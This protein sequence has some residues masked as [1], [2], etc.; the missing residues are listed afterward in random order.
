[1]E[2]PV[3]ERSDGLIGMWLD[4][5]YHVEAV[6]AR[7]GMSRVYR[8][9][10]T[11]L[12]RP[13]AI[14]VMERGYAAD[15]VFLERFEREARAAARLHHPGVV[16]VFDQGVDRSGETDHVFLV[17]ELVEGGTLRDLLRER[18]PLAVPLALSL[19]EPV[20]SALAAA[21][22]EG[23]VHRDVKPE[24]VL[25]GRGGAVK[26]ADFG[27]VR[28]AAEA[29]TSTGNVILGTVAYL[30]PEQVSTGAAD[31]RSDVYAAGIL[32]FELLTGRPPY[33]GETALAVAYRHVN[34]DVPA[35]SEIVPWLPTALD[36][37]VLRAT[38]RDPASRP[39]D[40]SAF[41]LA[42]QQLR[43]KLDIR[44]VPV[45]VPAAGPGGSTESGTAAANAAEPN[46]AEPNAAGSSGADG[47]PSGTRAMTR[48]DLPA[49]KPAAR[50]A[51]AH[52]PGPDSYQQQRLRS[53]RA[54]LAWL[55]VVL[56]L[57]SA[58]GTAAWW[59]GAGRWTSVPELAGL[60]RAAAAAALESAGLDARLVD[61]HH[62]TVTPGLVIGSEP[63]GGDRALRNTD[64][65]V[66][67]S[68][69]RPVVPDLPN[70]IS[71]DEA[72]QIVTDTDLRPVRNP[73]AAEF[74]D[75]VAEGDVVGLRPAAGTVLMVGAPVTL[76]ISRGPA[77]TTVPD[78][79]G[80]TEADATEALA[81]AG[82][83]VADVERQF[84]QD[85][86]GGQVIGT[87]PEAG[88]DTVRGTD[89]TL[90]VSTALVVP[91]VVGQQR[92]DALAALRDAGFEPEQ[93]GAG[94]GE[95]GATVAALDPR[96]GS[97]VDPGSNRIV[98]EMTTDV[99]VPDV[100]GRSV[101]EAR[102]ILREA[103]LRADVQQFF[104]DADSRVFAQFPGA[105]RTVERGSAVRLFAP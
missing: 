44:R 104:G 26:V 91:D 92:S 42:L 39:S 64:V 11:R 65:E 77:P 62:D 5:R 69:G 70:R 20:L 56:L 66:A 96:P 1:M 17:M 101:A 68:L 103:G 105:G 9:T 28:A 89:V 54:F 35:P 21:H 52:P 22:R 97:L 36:D 50:P 94:T 19:A 86:P 93:R 85:V 61:D 13:V 49:A 78:V 4:G 58:V 55:L 32:L 34:D 87:E 51:P 60:D 47:G 12:D 102:Q 25:I 80:S 73:G 16:G 74:S 31:A 15:P 82:L 27:L 3:A 7:G 33:S 100:E 81:D 2:R 71:P 72:S 79:R 24:N 46:A 76:V 14:K 57:A 30:S 23:L 29:G 75:T 90:V 37:L 38:Q 40:A 8:G 98:V 63:S 99:A 84:D 53:R 45:P 43:G 88:Q 6:I 59:L 83:T 41:L 95:S 18:G 67:I 10:D 48:T